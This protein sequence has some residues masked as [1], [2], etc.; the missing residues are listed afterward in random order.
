MSTTT[1]SHVASFPLER[2]LLRSRWRDALAGQQIL[3]YFITGD[4]NRITEYLCRSSDENLTKEIDSFR[5]LLICGPVGCG[6]TSIAIHLAALAAVEKQIASDIDSV[7]FL[8]AVDFAREYAEAVDSDDIQ[9]FREVIDDVPILVIDDV[10][11]MVDK[12]AA[13]EELAARLDMRSTTGLV[14]LLTSRRLPSDIEAI[15]SR[16]ASRAMSGLCVSLSNPKRDARKL[17]LAELALRHDLDLNETLIETL[18][19]RLADDLPVRALESATKQI[20][21][22]C[23]MNQTV[24]DQEAIAAAVESTGQSSEI[25]LS[26]ITQTIARMMGLKTGDLRSLSRK[27]SIVRARS[28]AMYI[29]RKSTRK[30]LQQIGEYYGGRDHST[31]LHSIRKIETALASDADLH[32]IYRDVV[33]KVSS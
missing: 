13:Q 22:W 9:P 14:T 11:L 3:P 1:T 6:K 5:P 20:S 25:E 16:L 18:N 15:R 7:K 27:Q 29:A 31:V 10:H 17:I 4:E 24:V 19:E 23:R 30:S 8:P 21:L 12:P 26:K 32:Q 33:A 28:L 2:P